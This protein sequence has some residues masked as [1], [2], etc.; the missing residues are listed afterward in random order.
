MVAVDRRPFFFFFYIWCLKGLCVK[1]YPLR[2]PRVFS[3]RTRPRVFLSATPFSRLFVTFPSEKAPTLIIAR[4]VP[5]SSQ[6]SD[7]PLSHCILWIPSPILPRCH[8]WPRPM[9][10]RSVRTLPITR[11]RLDS[12]PLVRRRF[13]VHRFDSIC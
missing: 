6:Q 9:N 13:Q 5:R 7:A 11:N 3:Y 12:R 8:R 4:V 1:L 10:T 2:F